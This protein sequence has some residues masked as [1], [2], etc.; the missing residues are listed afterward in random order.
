[1]KNQ[2]WVFNWNDSYIYLTG[3]KYCKDVPSTSYCGFK[4]KGDGQISYTFWYDGEAILEY[5][6]SRDTG[7][8]HIKKN[9]K[10]ITHMNTIGSSNLTFGFHAGD[11]LTIREHRSVINIYRLTLE[12]LLPRESKP[13]GKYNYRKTSGEI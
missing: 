1:M 8:V 5:G 9:N 7:S 6:Q 4:G 2:G 11:I 10:E 3:D 13:Q 12:R